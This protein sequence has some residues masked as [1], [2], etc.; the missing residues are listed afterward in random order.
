[1]RLSSLFILNTSSLSKNNEP[2][3]LEKVLSRQHSHEVQYFKKLP[4]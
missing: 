2:N 1:M 4:D 3:H